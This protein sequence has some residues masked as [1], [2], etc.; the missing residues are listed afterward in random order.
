MDYNI[1]THEPLEIVY[2]LLRLSHNSKSQQ[3]EIHIGLY[4][5]KEVPYFVKYLIMRQALQSGVGRLGLYLI[6]IDYASLHT[7]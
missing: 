1:K 7:A 6:I 5:Q 3:K 4:N 2:L